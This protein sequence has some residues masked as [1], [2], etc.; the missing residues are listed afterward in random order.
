MLLIAG[1]AIE[2][3]VITNRHYQAE[4]GANVELWTVP[5]VGHTAGLRERP[6]DYERR[7][8]RFLDDALG[9]ATR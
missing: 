9:L 2:E 4:G 6:A 1:G 8:T 3:E 5:G 7:T